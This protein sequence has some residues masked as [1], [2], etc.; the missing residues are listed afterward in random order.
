MV[1]ELGAGL[2]DRLMDLWRL[3]KLLIAFGVTAVRVWYAF[4]AGSRTDRPYFHN[5]IPKNGRLFLSDG[6]NAGERGGTV[7]ECIERD[8]KT[9]L[10][11]GST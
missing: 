8:T 6:T 3:G 1:K 9:L 4:D 2:H 7:R 10:N 11:G 5:R